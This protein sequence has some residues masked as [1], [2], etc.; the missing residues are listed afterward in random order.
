M[1]NVILVDTEHGVADKN[2][3]TKKNDSNHYWSSRNTDNNCRTRL[4]PHSHG[5]PNRNILLRSNYGTDTK[6]VENKCDNYVWETI[7]NQDISLEPHEDMFSDTNSLGPKAQHGHALTSHWSSHG[8]LMSLGKLKKP[9][10]FVELG[11]P[12]ASCFWLLT[13]CFMLL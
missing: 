2:K 12:Y 13:L 3:H 11:L 10:R 6:W 1:S 9:Q 5:E 8:K 4:Y 7:M